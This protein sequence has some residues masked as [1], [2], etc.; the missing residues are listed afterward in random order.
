V[1]G[2]MSD[3]V[4]G[5]PWPPRHG[6]PH[7]RFS[8]ALDE[9]L[10]PPPPEAGRVPS[11]LRLSLAPN[12]DTVRVRLALAEPFEMYEWADCAVAVWH[13]PS[14][15][16]VHDVRAGETELTVQLPCGGPPVDIHLPAHMDP[17][18][19]AV[20]AGPRDALA[21]PAE[22]GAAWIAYGDSITAG[23]SSPVPGSEWVAR[24]ARRIGLDVVN[25][26]LPAAAHG[27]DEQVSEVVALHAEVVTVA[28][29]TNCWSRIPR[30]AEQMGDA[31]RAVMTRIRAEHANAPLI[32]LSP[33]LRPAAEDVPNAVGATLADLRTSIE[34]TVLQRAAD[35][36]HLRLVRG[37]DLLAAEELVDGLHPGADGHEHLA[38]VLEGTFLDVLGSPAPRRH[39][40]PA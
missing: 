35:D 34:Q 30:R 22:R 9:T 40:R 11:G 14:L 15:A 1:D 16:H 29:G 23:W 37:R 33:L 39:G 12:G 24:V 31:M 28:I 20:N 38:A 36:S 4:R 10:P 18:V 21:E 26:G 19:L 7:P 32:V 27:G 5:A 3:V 13:G 2:V 25:L 8:S 17:E 6:R